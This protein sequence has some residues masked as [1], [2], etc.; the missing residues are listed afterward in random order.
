MCPDAEAK[1]CHDRTGLNFEMR[2]ERCWKCRK[3]STLISRVRDLKAS[4]SGGAK[5]LQVT[6]HKAIPT[7]RL[8]AKA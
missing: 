8:A 5:H 7:D 3:K 2:P 6:T 4:E 1:W